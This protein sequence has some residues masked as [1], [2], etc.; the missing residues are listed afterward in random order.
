MAFMRL[1]AATNPPNLAKYI[2]LLALDTNLSQIKCWW[3]NKV[4]TCE[5]EFLKVLIEQNLCFEFNQNS[6]VIAGGNVI[7]NGNYSE[8]YC[9]DKYCSVNNII[10]STV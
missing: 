1:L 4:T 3:N 8:K 2:A 7:S 10:S 5:N 6:S 9:F